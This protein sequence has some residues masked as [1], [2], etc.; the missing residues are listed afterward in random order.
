IHNAIAVPIA[1]AGLAMLL[2]AALAGLLGAGGGECIAS[3][4]RMAVLIY[5]VPRADARSPH[6][7]FAGICGR[8][9]IFSCIAADSKNPVKCRMICVTGVRRSRSATVLNPGAEPSAF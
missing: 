4:A 1:I 9:R 3:D 2:V 6:S 5:P 8:S 7:P